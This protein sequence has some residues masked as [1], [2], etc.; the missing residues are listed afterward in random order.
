MA[1]RRI[2]PSE[3]RKQK[4]NKPEPKL[5]PFVKKFRKDLAADR[6]LASEM[7]Q[8]RNTPGL[9][10]GGAEAKDDLQDLAEAIK[11]KEFWDKN[12]PRARKQRE[13]KRYQMS[14][15]KPPPPKSPG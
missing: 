7:G 2:R 15:T 12:N 3:H 14:R 1:S 10:P 8:I 9:Q 11:D 4:E 6:K 13:V 5:S